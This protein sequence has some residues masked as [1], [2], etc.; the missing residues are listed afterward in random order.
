MSTWNHKVLKVTRWEIVSWRTRARRWF[1]PER[2]Q[3]TANG[4]GS[5]GEKIVT[6]G[7]MFTH[8]S[9]ST[10]IEAEAKIAAA[11]REALAGANAERLAERPHANIYDPVNDKMTLKYE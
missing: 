9:A 3:A 11:I 2:W 6:V 8:Y 1:I 10:R 4:F 5:N 7:V